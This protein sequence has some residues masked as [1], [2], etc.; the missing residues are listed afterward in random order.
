MRGA[1][2]IP[3]AWLSAQVTI[4][5]MVWLAIWMAFH[6]RVPTGRP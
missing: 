5:S 1:F 3:E 4:E 2:A 6:R